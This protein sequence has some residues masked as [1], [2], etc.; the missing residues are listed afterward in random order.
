MGNSVH[1]RVDYV[2]V[3]LQH[4]SLHAVKQSPSVLPS[5]VCL[6]HSSV[7]SISPVIAIL[8]VADLYHAKRSKYLL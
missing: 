5:S 4:I 2:G 3:E 6:L 8:K 7:F 1:E